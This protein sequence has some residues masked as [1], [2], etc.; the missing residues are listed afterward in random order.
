MAQ[1]RMEGSE[2][3]TQWAKDLCGDEPLSLDLIQTMFLARGSDDPPG[4]GLA[5][6]PIDHAWIELECRRIL[7][8]SRTAVVTL[9]EVREALKHVTEEQAKII[10]HAMAV[11]TPG[12]SEE[13]CAAT[14]LSFC[15]HDI[16][17]MMKLSEETWSAAGIN[18]T[19]AR[20]IASVIVA[21][22]HGLHAGDVT[23]LHEMAQVPRGRG[24]AAR[25][26][27]SPRP[28]LEPQ[29]CPEVDRISITDEALGVMSMELQLCGKTFLPKR[30]GPR[31]GCNAC[32]EIANKARIWLIEAV[33]QVKRRTIPALA[34]APSFKVP[35]ELRE[36]CTCG[37]ADV[38]Q[39]IHAA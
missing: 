12:H 33:E 17:E 36:Q 13:D 24:M 14:I 30:M 28:T 25:S 32:G 4:T 3:A 38:G 6:E 8:M 21:N 19:R 18:M 39:V 9:R 11:E 1:V 26:M 27:P 2:G 29:T 22:R 10:A 7:G 35:Q 31:Y 16:E 23:E 20:I 34:S 37:Q 15:P 5:G